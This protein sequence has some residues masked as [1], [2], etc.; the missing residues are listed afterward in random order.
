MYHGHVPGVI[1]LQLIRDG[2]H[3]LAIVPFPLRIGTAVHVL[4]CL[5]SSIEAFIVACV[6]TK[7]EI[8]EK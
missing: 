7:G 6:A 1:S 3:Q 4:S 5:F 2:I 8:S